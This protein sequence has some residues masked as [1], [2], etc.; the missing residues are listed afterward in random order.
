[1]RGQG[2]SLER[3]ATALV[4]STSISGLLGVLFWGLATHI[5]TPAAVG[6]ASAEIS[7]M[8]LLGSFAQLSLTS[9]FPRFL[10]VAGPHVRRFVVLGYL[11]AVPMAFLLA[12]VFVAVGLGRS[13]LGLSAL[14]SAGFVA[15]VMCWTV[16]TI[17]D[18]ALVGLMSAVWVPVENIS[19]S[20]AKLALLPLLA[21]L[22]SGAGIFAAWTLPVIAASIP[23]NYF[24]FAKLIPSQSARKSGNGELPARRALTTFLAGEYLGGLAQTAAYLLLP[25]IVVARLGAAAN[26]YFYLS[27][28]AVGLLNEVLANIATPFVVESASAPTR[29]PAYARRM[30]KLGAAVVLPVSLLLV[31]GAP[32][33]LRFFGPAYA[34]H[35]STL[36]RLI[37]VAVPLRAVLVIYLAYARL[38]RQV[39][40][41]VAVQVINAILVLSL[42]IILL[43]Y[44]VS[45]VGVAYLATQAVMAACVIPS[46]VRHLRVQMSAIETTASGEE[47]AADT[48][49]PD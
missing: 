4:A 36:L 25:L 48:P 34:A 14:S 47:H 23:V 26:A 1:M 27:W 16:F 19:F 18:A 33:L 6:L 17:Q 37:G 12:T 38:A 42:S 45:G 28:I 5:F 3:N 24:I 41:I 10:P 20:I 31:F 39:Q 11:A 43:S 44:G 7:A 29:T 35:A 30:L 22:A 46:V 8:I 9:V 15:A 40:R 49:L 13:F 21:G 2:S 32:Y